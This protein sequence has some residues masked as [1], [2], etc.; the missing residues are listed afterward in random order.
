MGARAK[1]AACTS[2]LLRFGGARFLG[3]PNVVRST[4]PSDVV[5][6]DV[7]EFPPD[8]VRSTVPDFPPD[9]VRSAVP[10]F[11]TPCPGVA[12][13]VVPASAPVPCPAPIA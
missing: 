3:V 5:R 1:M 8:V 12:E 9:V 10:E 4:V 11:P 7:P 2:G 6:R 13:S